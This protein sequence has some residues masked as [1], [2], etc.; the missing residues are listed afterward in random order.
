MTNFILNKIISFISYFFNKFLYLYLIDQYMLIKKLFIDFF[1]E[2]K[3]LMIVHLIIILL[4]FP[5]ESI[6]LSRLFGDLFEKIKID[7]PKGSFL[8][9]Y[10]NIKKLN[11][12]GIIVIIIFIWLLVSFLYFTK[13]YLESIILPRYILYIRNLLLEILLKGTVMIIKI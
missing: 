5:V 6:I 12:P 4:I 10:E 8:D 1:H 9:Y 2:N 11:A 3:K 13:N 7:K